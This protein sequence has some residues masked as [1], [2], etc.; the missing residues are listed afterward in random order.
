MPGLGCYEIMVIGTG[1]YYDSRYSHPFD[2]LTIGGGSA[3]VITFSL[4]FWLIMYGYWLARARSVSKWLSF[5]PALP[6]MI[7]KAFD[8]MNEG[9]AATGSYWALFS[10]LLICFVVRS[11]TG[12]VND[13]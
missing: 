7:G 9:V 1:N 11:R 4:C 8:L 3:Q 10:G 6:L 13:K 12:I 2:P 5:L